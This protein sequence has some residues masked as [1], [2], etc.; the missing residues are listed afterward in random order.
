MIWLVVRTQ[1]RKEEEAERHL[2]KLGRKLG[3]EPY[4]PRCSK[5]ISHAGRTKDVL[6]PLF[7]GFLFV[8]VDPTFCR[9]G[10]IKRT[11]WVREILTN[12]ERPSAV[13]Q[14][15]IDEIKSRE[16]QGGGVVK[17]APPKFERGQAV[18]ITE[19]LLAGV[20]GL[21][22]EMRGK[23]RSMLLLSMLGRKVHI[24]AAAVAAA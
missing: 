12:G 11:I 2:R 4:L 17:L 21:F 9:W 22:E 5:D 20:D 18:R 24:A 23:G 6:R 3:F 15:V 1:Y 8:E 14:A 19:G 16:K 10:D 13:P 7:P